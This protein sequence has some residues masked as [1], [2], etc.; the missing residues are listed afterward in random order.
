MARNIITL[1]VSHVVQILIAQPIKYR[2]K[3][4]SASVILVTDLITIP[5]KHYIAVYLARKLLTVSSVK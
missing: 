3:M 2:G 5:I 4:D 1:T